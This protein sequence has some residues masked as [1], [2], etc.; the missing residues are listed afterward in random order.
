MRRHSP[1]SR[2]C[3][4]GLVYGGRSAPRT[5]ASTA[6]NTHGMYDLQFTEWATLLVVLHDSQAEPGLGK[7]GSFFKLPRSDRHDKSIRVYDCRF[8]N[9]P[10][11]PNRRRWY[12]NESSISLSASLECRFTLTS[13]VKTALPWPQHPGKPS[14]LPYPH[15]MRA[16]ISIRVLDGMLSNIEAHKCSINQTICMV[17]NI[18]SLRC[19]QD[20]SVYMD[21]NMP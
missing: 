8:V 2:C 20:T 13:K 16:G 12:Y 15:V 18:C 9:Q 21:N 14:R 10:Y 1:A 6:Y 11:P 3:Y 17:S 5:G 4:P 7:L 19:W